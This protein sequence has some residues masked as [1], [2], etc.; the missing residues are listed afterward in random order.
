MTCFTM[1]WTRMPLRVLC[2]MYHKGAV[3]QIL[4]LTLRYFMYY[5]KFMLV[6]IHQCLMIYYILHR[7]YENSF[8]AWIFILFNVSVDNLCIVYLHSHQ[9]LYFIHHLIFIPCRLIA[10]SAKVD[11]FKSVLRWIKISFL[12][13]FL[14]HRSI[15]SF[16]WYYFAE[17][18]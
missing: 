12:F 1:E 13:L 9:H 2:C 11:C 14:I 5:V 3:N 4:W 10:R 17:Y 15:N 8:N 18:W 16:I 6:I 7:S